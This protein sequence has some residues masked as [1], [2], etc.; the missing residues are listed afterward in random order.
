L[1]TRARTFGKSSRY[2]RESNVKLDFLAITNL[3]I[4]RI[5][6]SIRMNIKTMKE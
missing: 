3:V 5:F 6:K 2:S 1:F 4:H